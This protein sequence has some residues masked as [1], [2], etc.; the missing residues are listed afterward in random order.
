MKIENLIQEIKRKKSLL[1][2][3]LDSDIER[4]PEEFLKTSLPQYEFNKRIINATANYTI[5]YK[6]NL[7][8]YESVGQIGWLSLEF[9]QKYIKENYPGIF[10]IADAKR[11]DIGNTSKQY[12]KAFFKNLNF[13]AITLSPY[14]GYDVVA[15][16]LEYE[17]KYVIILALTSNKSA[18]EIQFFENKE[19][20]K[21]FEH[22]I[23][24]SINWGV[25]DKIMFVVGATKPE[26]F[27]TIRNIAP[28]NFL[29]V[30]G[31]GSQGGNLE[32]VIKNGINKN[33][34]LIINSSRSIIFAGSGYK[35]FKEKAAEEAEKLQQQISSLI[36]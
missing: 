5:A 19:G 21:L 28:D 23:N 11:G 16:F 22:I 9:T 7:A 10:T 17:D 18:N 25:S 20:I 36:F 12:A 4:I 32:L 8:F 14:M 27:N 26:Y 6:P 34:G 2:V 13:D 3:G 29:L 31:I 24:K 30:P 15:P 35:D 1:C 33:Y